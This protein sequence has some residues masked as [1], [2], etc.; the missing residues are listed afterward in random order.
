MEM[1]MLYFRMTSLVSSG[2]N[3]ASA[4][5]SKRKL[6]FADTTG[7]GMWL[8]ADPKL[9]RWHQVAHNGIRGKS[10]EHGYRRSFLP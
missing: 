6:H 9:V 7:A 1:V 4:P 3:Y 5:Q 8:A 2:H 10:Y